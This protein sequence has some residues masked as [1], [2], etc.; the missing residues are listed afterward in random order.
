MMHINRR[1]SIVDDRVETIKTQLNELLK[2]QK[3]IDEF[4]ENKNNKWNM[5]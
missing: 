5:I 4:L 1:K 3:N 2:E